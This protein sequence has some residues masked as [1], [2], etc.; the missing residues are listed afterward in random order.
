[1]TL[2]PEP[3]SPENQESAHEKGERGSSV[4]I[5]RAQREDEAAQRGG[6]LEEKT[7]PETIAE[8][9]VRLWTYG[10]AQRK[11]RDM[12][13]GDDEAVAGL[14]RG[15]GDGQGRMVQN[16]ENILVIYFNDPL[17]ALSAAKALQQK[18]LTTQ[19]GVSPNEQA[20]A[21]A[22]VR[23]QLHDAQAENCTPDSPTTVI[24]NQIL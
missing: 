19:N 21:A 17:H 4:E 23:V 12:A 13:W 1:M 8:L 9:C 10:G 7:R 24:P 15:L 2:H 16:H 20:V 6:A 11:L 3:N 14:V 18:L 5:T 22:L